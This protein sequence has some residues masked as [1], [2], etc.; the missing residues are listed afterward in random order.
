MSPVLNSVIV[1][2]GVMRPTKAGERLTNQ[3]FPSGPAVMSQGSL[4]VRPVLNSVTAPAGVTRAM[5]PF[6]PDWAIQRLPS[7]PWV[8]PFGLPARGSR[9]VNSLMSPSPA[10]SDPNALRLSSVNQSLPSSPE[11]MSQAP[12]SGLSPVWNSVTLG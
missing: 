3:R 8:M 7:G 5:A 2:S 12:L 6:R 9:P 4:G 1:P 11:T 10:L